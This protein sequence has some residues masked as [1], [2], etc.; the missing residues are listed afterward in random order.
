MEADQTKE[1]NVKKMLLVAGTALALVVGV[2]ST[3]P[4]AYAD[5]K[6]K[7]DDPD[8]WIGLGVG[9]K[10][11]FVAQEHGSA[12]SG[13]YG[14]RFGVDFQRFYINGSVHKYLKFEINTECFNCPS[15][16]NGTGG[17]SSSFGGNSTIGLLD[18]IGK[19]E[20]TP[21]VN[22]WVG[23][24][25]VPGERG[26]LNGPFYMAVYDGFKT[27]FNSADFSGNFGKGG[28][29]LYSRD[30][31]AVFW[32]EVNP[33]GKQLQYSLGVF[34]GLQSSGG[35]TVGACTGTCG[36]NQQGSLMYAGRLTFNFLNPEK[37]P[38]YYTSGTYYG[39][40]GDILALAVGVNHQKDGAGSF[41]ASSDFTAF[42][43]DLLFEKV[44][45][46]DGGVITVNAEYKQ[47]F[48]NYNKAVA[49]GGGGAAANGCF[50]MFDGHSYTGYAMYMFP[51]TVGIGKFQPYGRFT[52]IQP[53]ESS[54]RKETEAGVNYIIDGHNARL[55]AFWQY[56]DLATKGL[57]NYAPGVTGNMVNSI[58]LALQFQY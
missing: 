15:S 44:L 19:F 22:L 43:S 53:N 57:F 34:T 6:I 28:A 58:K 55:S 32:G 48:A 47:Y 9:V 20:F 45:P 16:I 37:N 18:A 39:K 3:P 50:C 54:N 33:G 13:S 41:A 31:G 2:A 35:G 11:S 5:G 52:W 42:I 4:S 49:F 56:G 40:G 29:G 38:G 51:Q 14:N 21:K 8:K 36:P 7:S 10:T 26:E 17:G 12:N 27:P 24:L 1:W 23:R 25:L 30:N 46:N